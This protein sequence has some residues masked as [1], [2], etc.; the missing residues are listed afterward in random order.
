G[1]TSIYLPKKAMGCSEATWLNTNRYVP[2]VTNIG[3]ARNERYSKRLRRPP[4]LEQLRLGP[5]FEHDMRGRLNV[6]ATVTF[7]CRL[8]LEV[9]MQRI[10]PTVLGMLAILVPA[11]AQNVAEIAERALAAAPRQLREGATIIQWKADLTY[12]TL[13]KGTNRLVCYDRS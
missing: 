2:P 7:L 10:F 12:E 1:V 5:G 4:P 8:G 11:V 9:R 6:R 3:L 13:K